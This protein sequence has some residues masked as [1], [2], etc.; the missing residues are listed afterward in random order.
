MAKKSQP[1]GGEEG[2][3]S[4]LDTVFGQQLSGDDIGERAAGLDEYLQAC[5][6]GVLYERLMG[7]DEERG[8]FKR[9]LFADVLYGRDRYPS[10]LRQRF[11]RTYPAIGFVL[12]ELKAGDYRRPSWT[13]QLQE[14]KLFIGGIC[15]RIRNENPDIPLVTV[16]D[17]VATTPDFVEYVKAVAVSEFAKLGVAPTF[18]RET[19]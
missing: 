5:Q 12:E 7:P 11:H 4:C 14:S 1:V 16:H 6:D 17:S 19:F 8:R 2:Y 13:T 10:E 15:N 18:H 3:E 9:R